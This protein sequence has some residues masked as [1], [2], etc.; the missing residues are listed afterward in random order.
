MEVNKSCLYI[1]YFSLPEVGASSNMDM[2]DGSLAIFG[3]ARFSFGAQ[4]NSKIT[5]HIQRGL[6]YT[7][8]HFEQ[9]VQVRI[10]SKGISTKVVTSLSVVKTGILLLGCLWVHRIW[11]VGG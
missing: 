3:L 5:R 8:F 9:S 6:E 2:K 11:E 1:V 7:V 10:I 4:F